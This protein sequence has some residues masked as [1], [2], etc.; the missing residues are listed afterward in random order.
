V[1]IYL[2]G[3]VLGSLTDSFMNSSYFE[4]SALKEKI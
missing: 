2:Y 3:S 4:Y 1:H